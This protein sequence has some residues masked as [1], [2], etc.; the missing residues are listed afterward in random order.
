MTAWPGRETSRCVSR[1]APLQ[2]PPMNAERIDEEQAERLA[3]RLVPI[4]ASQ[5]QALESLER[6]F[7]SLT[8]DFWRDY[9]VDHDDRI[10]GGLYR[11]C[12]TLQMIVAQWRDESEDVA[13]VELRRRALEQIAVGSLAAGE[14]R[15]LA[16]QALR[17]PP[18]RG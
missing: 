10:A 12:S 3:V 18:A 4:A 14:A 9:G 8:E 11:L 13:I 1:Q 5:I 17:D 2:L 16:A 6:A 15:R 7:S